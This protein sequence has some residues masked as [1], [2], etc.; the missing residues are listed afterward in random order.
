MVSLSAWLQGSVQNGPKKHFCCR[1]VVCTR[2]D[3]HLK[4]FQR[5]NSRRRC[6]LCAPVIVHV[7]CCTLRL[8]SGSAA[9]DTLSDL[10][11]VEM[12]LPREPQEVVNI[13]VQEL[14]Q[15][16]AWTEASSAARHAERRA[17][18]QAHP[19]IGDLA[20][21]AL[22]CFET[23]LKVHGCRHAFGHSH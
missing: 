17:A 22:F 14:L 16:V 6:V 2:F 7:G 15:G 8:Y 10:S 11:F 13:I 23:A 5:I 21:E 1:S 18:E 9:A 19:G 20:G 4:Y 12:T 3:L